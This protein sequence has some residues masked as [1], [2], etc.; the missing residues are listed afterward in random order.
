MD[1]FLARLLEETKDVEPWDY[2]KNGPAGYYDPDGDVTF[3]HTS[4]DDYY[5]E[6]LGSDVSVYRERDEKRIV[7]CDI[8]GDPTLP[9]VRRVFEERQLP[10][11]LLE[12]AIKIYKEQ[13]PSSSSRQG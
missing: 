9:K 11:E 7:G 3:V 4:H 6:W 13:A 1:E 10:I 2:E 5:A 12:L 8:W